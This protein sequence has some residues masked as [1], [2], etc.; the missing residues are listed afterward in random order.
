MWSPLLGVLQRGVGS[1]SFTQ[2]QQRIIMLVI[3]L[4]VLCVLSGL[5]VGARFMA[6][7]LRYSQ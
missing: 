5:C 7:V 4:G 1:L 3:E 2:V 6:E